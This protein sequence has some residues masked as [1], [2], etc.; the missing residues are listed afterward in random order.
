MSRRQALIPI[1]RR[2]FW[3]LINEMSKAG[4]TIFVT[5]H[6]MDEADYCN[7]LALIYRGRIIAEGTPNELKQKY[8]TRYVLEV[9]TDNLVQA[10]EVLNESGIEAAIFGSLLHVTVDNLE[11]AVPQIREFLE[12]ADITCTQDRENCAVTGRCI[13][14][15]DR[16]I[17]KSR[18]C[19]ASKV[20]FKARPQEII[21]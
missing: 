4:I 5:T 15:I 21:I 17:V 12:D 20:A 10:M 8:M 18:T 14:D 1:S 3:N 9:E 6:Y 19:A 7:R 13:C 11:K 2:N 16:D